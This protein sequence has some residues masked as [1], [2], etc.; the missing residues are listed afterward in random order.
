MSVILSSLILF[1]H[2]HSLFLSTQHNTTQHNTTQ[3][4]TTQHN[5]TQHTTQHNTTHNTQHNTTQHTT[6]NTTQH[7]TQHTTH[8]TTQHNT[9]QHNTTQHNTTQHNTG[10][11]YVYDDEIECQFNTRTSTIVCTSLGVGEEEDAEECDDVIH[12]VINE[13]ENLVMSDYV[14]VKQM[15][16]HN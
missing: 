7:N 14:L 6:H 2:S 15:N 4:N 1:S 5:N 13:N 3:H 10:S 16:T 11:Y 8:N 12:F 9:T